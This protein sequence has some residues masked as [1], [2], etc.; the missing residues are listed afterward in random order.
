MLNGQGTINYIDGSQYTGDFVDSLK[1][2]YGKMEF[3]NGNS[4]EG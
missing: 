3:P 2:G 4:Y 1:E